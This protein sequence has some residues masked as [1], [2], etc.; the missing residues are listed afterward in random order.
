ML[1]WKENSEA[2]TRVT[3][4]N[5][6]KADISHPSSYLTLAEMECLFPFYLNALKTAK[7]L[8]RQPVCDM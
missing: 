2:C 1:S 8:C 3:V 7:T 6:R 5:R 4:P